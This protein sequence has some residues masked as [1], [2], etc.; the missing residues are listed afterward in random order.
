MKMQGDHSAPD[1]IIAKI[2]SSR[3]DFDTTPAGIHRLKLAGVSDRIVLAMLHAP[4][5][6][7]LVFAD[8]TASAESNDPQWH[9]RRGSGE[10]R[11]L[12]ERFARRID[13]GNVRGAGRSDRWRDGSR[14]RRGGARANHGGSPRGIGKR[15]RGGVVHAGRAGGE[16]R[17]H[18]GEF[19]A[20]ARRQDYRSE[21][22]PATRSSCL[23][24]ARTDR[25]S[26]RP[27]TTSP[28]S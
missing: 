8:G 6:F 23:S 7:P 24:F 20:N 10:Q 14:E 28:P 12:A 22:S 16:R 25:R 21:I 9:F 2:N 4:A 1:E 5:A 26:L 17:P 13:R 18:S 3:C 15:G 27:E 19:C 11:R